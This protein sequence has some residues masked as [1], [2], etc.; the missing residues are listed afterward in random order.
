[1]VTPFTGVWIEIIMLGVGSNPVEV[2]PFTGVWIEIPG[3][4]RTP[5][6]RFVTPFTGVWIEIIQKRECLAK[7]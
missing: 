6:A 7:C 1:M 2:T 4:S 5:A 3:C